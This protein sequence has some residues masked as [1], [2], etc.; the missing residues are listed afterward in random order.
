MGHSEDF[1]DAIALV[2]CVGQKRITPAPA[3]E[4]YRSTWFVKARSYVE[5]GDAEWL[6]LSALYGLVAPETIIA[7]YEK[8]LNKMGV[9]QR[10]EWADRVYGELRPRLSGHK[11]VVFFAGRRYREFLAPKLIAEGY[12][13]EVPMEGLTIGRQLAWLSR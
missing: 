1:S 3:R 5:A 7:P 6:I 2:S 8:T 11:R 13:V 4:L 9:A 10:R 12:R